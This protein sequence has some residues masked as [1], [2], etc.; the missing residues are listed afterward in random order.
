MSLRGC[1]SSNIELQPRNDIIGDYRAP[2]TVLVNER[3]DGFFR[4]NDI[5]R[6]RE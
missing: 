3:E 2:K 4:G 6:S 5:K 1:N